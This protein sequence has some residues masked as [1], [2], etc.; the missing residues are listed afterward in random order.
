MTTIFKI[1]YTYSC[2]VYK[3]TGGFEFLGFWLFLSE[4][5]N[6]GRDSCRPFFA[7]FLLFASLV[8]SFPPSYIYKYIYIPVP[9]SPSLVR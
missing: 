1:L 5:E 8:A 7:A 4:G 6:E 3:T 2:S 9:P